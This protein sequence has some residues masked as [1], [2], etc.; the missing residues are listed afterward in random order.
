MLHDL[1]FEERFRRSKRRLSFIVALLAGLVLNVTPLG[2]VEAATLS[3]CASGCDATTIADA[4]TAA[5]AGDTI[6][7]TDAVHTEAGISVTKDLTIQGL[8]AA[9]TTVNGGGSGPVF[10]VQSG[11]TAMIQNMTISNGVAT[12][13][14]GIYN[15]GGT[16]TISHTSLSGNSSTDTGGGGGGIYNDI[17]ATLT[18]NDSTFSG[19][20][21]TQ[22]GGIYNYLGTLTVTN[23]TLSGNSAPWGG[24]DQ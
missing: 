17:Y 21:A 11:V 16:L 19:N 13:G 10:T 4:I 9:S 12:S 8:G 24:R 2:S 5:S 23:T 1:T 18:I 6:A 15:A 22:G 20:S 7:V 14:G 3:V